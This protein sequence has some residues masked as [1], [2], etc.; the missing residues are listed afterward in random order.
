VSIALFFAALMGFLAS[1]GF[2][3]LGLSN[4]V[5]RYPLATCVAYAVFL[6]LLRV[7]AR[8]GWDGRLQSSDSTHPRDS[9]RDS[10]DSG[11]DSE[12]AEIG[13]PEGASSDFE[14]PLPD[15]D[16]GLALLVPLLMLAGG[17][18]GVV[19]LIH[20]APLLLAELILDAVVVASLARRYRQVSPSTGSTVPSATPIVR[21]WESSSR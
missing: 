11:A 5:V 17:I 10:P 18:V 14:F 21:S 16:E 4:M 20:I 2:L 7:F 12:P 3:Q 15:L 9:S 13:S 19:Y 1:Y 6:L 8:Y